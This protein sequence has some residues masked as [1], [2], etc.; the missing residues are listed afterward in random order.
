VVETKP[1]IAVDFTVKGFT[2]EGTFTL[3]E[4]R[5]PIDGT[6]RAIYR[7]TDAQPWPRPPGA[8]DVTGD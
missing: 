2:L 3:S 6:L 5:D 4:L 7:I 8:L 1:G